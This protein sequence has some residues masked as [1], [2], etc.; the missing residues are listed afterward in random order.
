MRHIVFLVIWVTVFVL[1]IISK[2]YFAALIGLF[3]IQYTINK[4]IEHIREYY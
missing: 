1:S 4:L 3:T 2:D